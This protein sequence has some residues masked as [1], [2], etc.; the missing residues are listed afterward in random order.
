MSRGAG[1]VYGYEADAENCRLARANLREFK[2]KVTVVRAAV[3]RSDSPPAYLLFSGYA[4]LE[5]GL[6]NTGSGDVLGSKGCRIVPTLVF[7]RIVDSVTSNGQRRVRLL[8][9]DCEG[10]EYPI[11]MT[12]E[13]LHL[14][15]EIV[16]EYHELSGFADGKGVSKATQVG[17]SP[18]WSGEMLGQFLEIQ[19]FAVRLGEKRARFGKFLAWN[20]SFLASP[21]SDS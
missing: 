2:A 18:N 1:H 13:R 19:G 5:N 17:A 4:R 7:D 15:D 16:G 14:V 12:S 21:F 8:K 3:C 6:V 20:R 11:L 10:S 9:L